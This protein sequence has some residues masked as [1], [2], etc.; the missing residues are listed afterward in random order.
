MF[1]EGIDDEEAAH[2]STAGFLDSI[3][4]DDRHYRRIQILGA[5]VLSSIP[6]VN[7]VD[8]VRAVMAIFQC[9]PLKVEFPPSSLPNEQPGIDDNSKRNGGHECRTPRIV[10]VPSRADR[11]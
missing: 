4:L 1:R 9:L 3:R 8:P 5:F 11:R 6:H 7:S 10:P 2:P